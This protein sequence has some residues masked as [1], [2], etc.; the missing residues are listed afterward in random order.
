MISAL[1][2]RYVAPAAIALL[3]LAG[4]WANGYST[5]K[6]SAKQEIQAYKADSA[7]A[8]SKAQTKLASE[9]QTIL[10]E[11][12]NSLQNLRN[13]RDSLII[14][15]RNRQP[16]PQSTSSTGGGAPE[17]ATSTSCSPKQLYREDA[18]ALAEL[19]GDAE[20]VRRELLSTRAMYSSARDAMA[21]RVVDTY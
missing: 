18:E 12:E 1:L 8:N 13:E 14:S 19:A 21:T 7:L 17:P 5:G 4:V 16:R 6:Q 2:L 15:L 20:A 9:F 3:L 10:L 11:R